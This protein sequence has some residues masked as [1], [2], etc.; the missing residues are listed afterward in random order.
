MTRWL[1]ELA[2]DPM[3][4]EEFPNWFPDGDVFAVVHGGKH[5]LTG[6]RF[7]DFEDGGT[8]RAEAAEILKGMSATIS[9][10]WPKLVPPVVGNVIRQHDDGRRDIY[11]FPETGHYRNKI[12]PPTVTQEGIDTPQMPTQAQ[13]ILLAAQTSSHLKE[14]LVVWADRNRSWARLYRV[15]ESIERHLGTSASKAG[16]C[17]ANEAERFTRS[18]NSSDVA[19]VDARHASG[20]FEPPKHPMTLPEA[21][22]F[23]RSVFEKILL[24]MVKSDATPKSSASD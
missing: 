1:I 6:N 22:E 21:E 3:D 9:L 8:V 17:S 18:A 12:Y 10:L 7:E 4:T 5:Y 20:K 2:G 24:Q 16:F 14:A 23:V 11:F 19:G 15:L 13:R